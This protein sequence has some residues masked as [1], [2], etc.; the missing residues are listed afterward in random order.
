MHVLRLSKRFSIYSCACALCVQNVTQA[1]TENSGEHQPGGPALLCMPVTPCAAA[2]ASRWPA[3]YVR[4]LVCKPAC[5]VQLRRCQPLLG[6]RGR[7]V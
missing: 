6:I 1:V 3:S 4:P 5:S 7:I 2:K